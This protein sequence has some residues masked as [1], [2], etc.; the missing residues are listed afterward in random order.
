VEDL[1]E[2][3]PIECWSILLASNNAAGLA[4]S[5][6]LFGFSASVDKSNALN[7]NVGSF[8]E[9]YPAEKNLAT[10]TWC[11]YGQS[12]KLP[13][14]LAHPDSDTS[15]KFL[16]CY[17]LYSS[18]QAEDCFAASWAHFF[19]VVAAGC[20]QTKSGKE[21]HSLMNSLAE[22]SLTALSSVSESKTISESILSS[23]GL[24]ESTDT[25]PI[26]D[27]CSLLLYSLS[28]SSAFDDIEND[29]DRSD[30]LLGM[31]GRLYE[32]A[33]RLF[34]MTQLGSA[35]SSN[36]VRITIVQS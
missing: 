18:I 5:S 4:A 20:I 12:T 30:I 2:P 17:T 16:E 26:G 10:S 34:A 19:E 36:Q 23:Q 8:L 14:A 33:N 25:K 3:G 29:D 31:F 35:A 24:S 9:A 27:L 28:V 32:S 15:R 1:F 13:D 6:W 11:R 7:W 21:V 22:C